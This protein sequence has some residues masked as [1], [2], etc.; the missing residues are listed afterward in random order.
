MVRRHFKMIGFPV[1]GDTR[2]GEGDKKFSRPV[3]DSNRFEI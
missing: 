2:Y 1:M 3:A